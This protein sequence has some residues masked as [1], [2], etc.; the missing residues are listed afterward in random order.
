[1]SVKSAKI[2]PNRDHSSKPATT[3]AIVSSVDGFIALCDYQPLYF[4]LF[5]IHNA[6]LLSGDTDWMRSCESTEGTNSLLIKRPVGT[7][8]VLLSFGT[9]IVTL[10][11]MMEV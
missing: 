10:A 9:L 7:V 6:R 1:M 5:G 2:R 3:E 11:A 4:Y 8:I